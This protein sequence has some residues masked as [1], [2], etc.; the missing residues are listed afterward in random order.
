MRSATMPRSRRRSAARSAASQSRTAQIEPNPNRKAPHKAP[1][2]PVGWTSLEAHARCLQER[3]TAERRPLRSRLQS[4]CGQAREAE[5]R[6]GLPVGQHPPRKFLPKRPPWR[7]RRSAARPM[8]RRQ[9][10][11]TFQVYRLRQ[12]GSMQ[13]AAGPI[14][15]K[16]QAW[17]LRPREQL[18]HR[19][20]QGSLEATTPLHRVPNPGQRRRSGTEAHPS[21]PPPQPAA[22]LLGQRHAELPL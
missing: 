15:G 2:P 5:S 22:G 13:N 19:A 9:T 3:D 14:P 7:H 10:D 8:L 21:P 18:R 1:H 17:K 6:P 12:R 4:R 20:A 16:R 11:S